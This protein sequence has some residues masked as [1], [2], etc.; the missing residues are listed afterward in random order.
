MAL[1]FAADSVSLSARQLLCERDDRVLFENLDLDVRNGDLLQLAGPNG[2]GKTTLLRLL[3]GLNRDYEGDLLWHAEPLHDCFAEYAANRVYLG[4]L[5]AI[6]RALTPIENLR[7]LMSPWQNA[8][9]EL[10][11]DDLWQALAEVQLG[12]FE[13]TPCN[14]LSAGQQR[15]VGLSRLALVPAPLWILDEPFTALD[16]EGVSWLEERIQ[17]QVAAGGAVIITSH[18]ALQGIPSLRRL[19]LGVRATEGRS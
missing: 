7:W 4:H 2:A 11:E 5:A 3:A 16:V 19:E 12:G 6:K 1:S 10:H 9:L 8:G 18:H 13:D 17:R 15:R 14:Q